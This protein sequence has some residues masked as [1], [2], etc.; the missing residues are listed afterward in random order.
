[1]FGLG[2]Q[3]LLTLLAIV[4]LLFGWRRLPEIGH[5]FGR[6]RQGFTRGVTEGQEE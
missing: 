3:Q 4:L 5:S 1:M 2:V 6:A